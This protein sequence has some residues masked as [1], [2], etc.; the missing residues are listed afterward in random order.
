MQSLLI[1]ED[2]KSSFFPGFKFFRVNFIFFSCK[3][4]GQTTDYVYS[5]NYNEKDCGP[6]S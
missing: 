2:K 6:G 4:V 1:L 3:I 5:V